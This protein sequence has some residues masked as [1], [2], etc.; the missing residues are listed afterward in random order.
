MRKRELE[1]KEEVYRKLADELARLREE[2]HGKAKSQDE[3]F[4]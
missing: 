4:R 2:W 3:C 1:A